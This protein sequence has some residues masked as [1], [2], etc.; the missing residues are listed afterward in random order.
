MKLSL[1]V[2]NPGMNQAR[3]WFG[4]A[5]L[6]VVGP[7][8]FAV[9]LDVAA[10]D[11]ECGIPK[12]SLST[13]LGRGRTVQ[14]ALKEACVVPIDHVAVFFRRS[15]L[16]TSSA[17]RM[18][19]ILA[20]SAGADGKRRR[21]R[22]PGS[23]SIML[24]LTVALVVV[25][26]SNSGRL[27]PPNLAHAACELLRGRT[28]DTARVMGMWSRPSLCGINLSRKPRVRFNPTAP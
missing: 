11:V 19:F 28:E 4:P 26:S 16:N 27:P 24:L 5:H 12:P 7:D 17:F 20:S 6:V 18:H 21:C 2:W 3:V 14:V 23:P 8:A 10:V 22:L 9:E 13:C 25:L 15:L 1:L